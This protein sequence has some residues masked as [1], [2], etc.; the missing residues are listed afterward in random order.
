M[1]I[2]ECQFEEGDRIDH[3][4]FGFGTVS[5]SPVPM[6]G[7]E[8]SAPSG[9]IDKGWR[10]PVQWDDP[11]RTATSVAD[12]ALRK[13]ASPDSR[14]FGYWI[15]QWQPLLRAWLAARRDVEQAVNNFRP[16]PAPSYT[17]RLQDAE[18]TA[19]NAMNRFLDEER[20][21]KHA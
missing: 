21:G 17:A 16:R 7:P 4:I 10:I 5:G 6:A 9:V 14:P 18:T 19:L 15:R 11:T 12:W 3:R 13:V 1:A 20:L 2:A 8:M